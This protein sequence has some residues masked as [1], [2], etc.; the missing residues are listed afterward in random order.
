MTSRPEFEFV[1][2]HPC[3]DFVNTVGGLR[4][5]V[6][7]ELLADGDALIR[8]SEAARL[9]RQN[10][11]RRLRRAARANPRQARV[12]LSRAIRLREALYALLRPGRAWA[13]ERARPLKCVNQ[14]LIVA[15]TRRR[16]AKR[17]AGFSQEW[18][19]VD[20]GLS[21][22]LGPIVRAAAELL[23]SD[24]GRRIRECAGETCGWLFLDVSRNG[25]RRWCDMRVCGNRA[26]V[27]RHRAR[28]RRVARAPGR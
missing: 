3:L 10:E 17:G 15:Q 24:H 6:A 8:W 26:K 22:L 20:A 7:T 27:R 11:G 4:G 5:G 25:R 23:T 18:S 1:G 12:A 21:G 14:E 2:G 28:H 9:I 13:G 19:D 16:I